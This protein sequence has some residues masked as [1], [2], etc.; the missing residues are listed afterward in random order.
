MDSACRHARMCTKR[1]CYSHSTANSEADE[2]R[3]IIVTGNGVGGARFAW[4][5]ELAF[6]VAVVGA[7][8][9]IANALGDVRA[10]VARTGAHV[11]RNGVL[12]ERNAEAIDRNAKAIDRNAKAIDRNADAI[13]R[14]AEAI[15][16][17]KASVANLAGQFAEHVR[18]HTELAGR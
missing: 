12:I 7:A 3:T 4:T 17:V 11:Q 18:E 15:G 16:E 13:A 9:V 2:Q 8:W 14:N 6:V 5:R 1:E 10:E